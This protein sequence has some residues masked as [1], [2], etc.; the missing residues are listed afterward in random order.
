MHDS[1]IIFVKIVFVHSNFALGSA[2]VVVVFTRDSVV[3]TVR[4]IVNAYVADETLARLYCY[5]E[6]QHVYCTLTCVFFT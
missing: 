4:P 5:D 1:T 3:C 2:V 6:Y